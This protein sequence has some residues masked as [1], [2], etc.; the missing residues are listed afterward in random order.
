MGGPF[1]A[2]KDERAWSIPKGE[3]QPGEDPLAAAKREFE[4]ELGT[5]PPT[6]PVEPLGQVKQAGGKVVSA[7]CVRGD[8]DPGALRS[9]TFRLEWP[10]RSGRMQ[11]FP[12]IDR[13]GWFD[14]ESARQKLVRGQE[15]FLDHLLERIG[16]GQT[17][18]R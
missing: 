13:A 18:E 4:E 14:I 16:G 11:E 15:A 7:W 1:W 3:Y 17:P 12:E 2:R 9:N 10:P 5:P 6:G 8:F